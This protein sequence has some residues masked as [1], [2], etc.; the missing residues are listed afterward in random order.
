MNL[1]STLT[2]ALASSVMQPTAMAS[3]VVDGPFDNMRASN[4]A[5]GVA[6]NDGTIL[7]LPA[8][9]S[10]VRLISE[11]VGSLPLKL[12]QRHPNGSAEPARDSPLYDLLTGAANNYQ[13]AN[14]F[15]TLMQGRLCIRH[16]AFAFIERRG[17]RIVR[18]MPVHPAS[19]SMRAD[20]RTGLVLYDVSAPDGWVERNIPASR[21]LHIR[22]FSDSGF[23]GWGP[24]SILKDAMGGAIA[25]ERY[26]QR[27]MANGAHINGFLRVPMHLTD[28]QVQQFE[29]MLDSYRGADNAG[30]LPFFY[31]E[32]GGGSV[33]YVK[34]GMT[35]REAE[36]LGTRRLLIEDVARMFRVPP[37]LIGHMDQM[38]RSNMETQGAEFLTY[39]LQPWLTRWEQRLDRSI[40]TPADRRRGFFYRFETGALVRANLQER[41][42]AYHQALQGW[43]SPNEVRRLEDLPMVAGGDDVYRPLNMEALNG[44]NISD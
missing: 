36:I 29:R 13:S 12:M 32:G 17:A 30:R 10:A 8:A 37:H 7:G 9:Y 38:T 20:E 16:N 40:L 18:L 44:E 22:G 27:V 15:I 3:N 25:A 31:G 4:S 35:A 26:T 2:S 19:V 5:A 14:E 6:V 1:L 41:Y 34:M 21:M 42:T 28:E 43:M 24:A 23:M 39:S 33:E 11:T